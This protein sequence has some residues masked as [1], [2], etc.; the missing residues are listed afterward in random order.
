MVLTIRMVLMS[1]VLVPVSSILTLRGRGRGQ[2]HLRDKQ[3]LH[4]GNQESEHASTVHLDPVSFGSIRVV[5]R[6]ILLT[7]LVLAVMSL[8]QPSGAG[9]EG[10]D[11][12][13]QH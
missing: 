11:R 3:S 8:S 10:R 1:L 6:L 5:F 7:V 2:L 4:Q 9:G 12:H 13:K